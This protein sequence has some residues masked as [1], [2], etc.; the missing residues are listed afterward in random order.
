MR[1]EGLEPPYPYGYQILSLARLPV[2]PLSRR[3]QSN[4]LNC[5]LPTS[6]FQVPTASS[7][8]QI[9][10]PKSQTPFRMPRRCWKLGVGSWEFGFG[11]YPTH[12]GRMRSMLPSAASNGRAPAHGSVPR[13]ILA[14]AAGVGSGTAD[15]QRR[16]AAHH[17]RSAH[18]PPADDFQ[19]R[20]QRTGHLSGLH[21]TWLGW[22][23]FVRFG[24]ASGVRV[25]ELRDTRLASGRLRRPVGMVASTVPEP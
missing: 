24:S 4:T 14:L 25:S 19:P 10:N 16:C 22:L 6:N 9:P 15:V 2:P 12:C 11:K 18:R 23:C 13:F 17:S 3:C 1:K 7:K 5:Q 21:A 20:A 8:S